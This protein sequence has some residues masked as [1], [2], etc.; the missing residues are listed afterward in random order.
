MKNAL[1]VRE[2][3]PAGDLYRKVDR[4]LDRQRP[5][6]G[7]SFAE[8][9]TNHQ[10]HDVEVEAP[11]QAAVDQGYD[12][13][14]LEPTGDADFPGEPARPK[15]GREL[16]AQDLDG[17]REASAPVDGSKHQ[18]GGTR[19]ERLDVPEAGFERLAN[20]LDRRIGGLRLGG[21]GHPPSEGARGAEAV[22]VN[23]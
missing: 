16:R 1:I 7:Q 22:R 10:R 9:L 19:T 13:G 14:V 18:R 12:V 15:R 11:G 3:K 5:L 6:A 21:F 20:S 17:N 8:G 23:R 4:F 2:L